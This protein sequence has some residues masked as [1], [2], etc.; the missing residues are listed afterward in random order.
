ML[1]LNHIETIAQTDVF[2]ILHRFDLVQSKSVFLYA[3]LEEPGTDWD[4]DQEGAVQIL[5]GGWM[6]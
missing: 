6:W 3:E 2:W 5:S 4:A 1:L